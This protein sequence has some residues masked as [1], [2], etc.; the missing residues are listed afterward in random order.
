MSRILVVWWLLLVIYCIFH[1]I[2]VV[3]FIESS[4]L[5]MQDALNLCGNHGP[6]GDHDPGLIAVP[7]K[8]G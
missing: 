3:H 2:A 8:I 4:N 1:P 7:M 5:A 6:W